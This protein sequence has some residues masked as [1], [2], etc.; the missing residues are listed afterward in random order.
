MSDL[1]S[2]RLSLRREPLRDEAAVVA[3]RLAAL[4]LDADRRQAVSEAGRA[5]V[6]RMR[7]SGEVTMMDNMLAEYGLSTDEGVALMCLAEAYLRVPDAPTLDALIKDKIGGRDWAEH[8][9]ESGSMLVNASTWGL[10][11]TGRLYGESWAEDTLLGSVRKMVRRVG[12]PV[13]RTAVAQCMKIM[14]A[15]FVLGRTIDEAW[16]NGGPLIEKGY[17]YSF[18]M[19]GEAARTA[20]DATH[21]FKAYANAIAAVGAR[22]TQADVHANSGISVKLSALHPRYEEVNRARVMAE[23]V[24]RLSALAEMAAAVN[25]GMTV[26]AEEADRL[27]LSLSVMEAV[28]RNPNLAGWGGF[29]IVVQAYLKSTLPTIDWIIALAR[30]LDR[31]LAVRLVKG[32]YWDAEIKTA[33]S[34]ALPAYPVFTR[35][36]STD[37]SY[38]ASAARLLGAQDHIYPMFAGHNA[39]TASAVLEMAGPDAVFEFQRLHGMGETLHE[40]LRRDHGHRCRIY[41]PVGVHKDLLAYLVRR[42]LENG[43]NSSFVNQALDKDVPA[44]ELTRDPATVVAQASSVAHAGIPLPP[45][46]FG[47]ERANSK[48]WN[49]NNPLMAA[50]LD[51]R[52]TPFRAARW[53]A[54]PMIGATPPRSGGEAVTNPADRDE[55][56][57]FVVS[58][59]ANDVTVALETTTRAFP[60]WRDRAPAER[61]ALLD[62]I[63]ALY[64]EHAP[65]LI[66]LLSREAGKTRW[67]G[68]LEVREAVDF[69]RYYAARSRA[70]LAGSGRKGRGVFVCISPWNFPLAIFTGQI[71][72]ALVS[73]NTV[74]A[75]PAEQTPLIAARAVALMREAGVPP[76]VLALLPGE[77]ASVGAALT[78]SPLVAGVCF[79]GSTETAIAIDRAQASAGTGGAPLIAETGGLNAMI[80]DSTALPEHAVRDIVAGAFQSAGQRCSALRALF[81]Q[82]DIADHLLTMLAGAVQE[83]VVGNP[84]EA[85]TD[86]GPVIDAEAKAVI[87][88][89]CEALT[90]AGRRLFVHDKA[91]AAKGGGF[92]A[93]VAFSLDR[94]EDLKSEIFGPVLHVIRFRNTEIDA[95]VDSINAAGYGL[96][97]GIHSRVDAQVERICSRARV[98]NI[99]VNRNQI[100]AVVGVQPFGGE[101][102]SGTGPK[103]GGPGYL[104]RFTIAAPVALPEVA[105]PASHGEDAAA[106]NALDAAR[107]AASV[108]PAW[109]GRSDRLAILEAA[110]RALPEAARPTASAVLDLAKPLVAPPLD[111][112]GVTGESNR[113]AL[114]GRGVVLC[115]GGGERPATALLAQ[116]LLGLAAGNAVLL[117]GDP[118]AG[119]IAALRKALA[120][121][122]LSAGLVQSI[123]ASDLPGLLREMP[124]LA[125]VAHEGGVGGEGLRVALAA[126]SGARVPLVALVDGVGRYVSERV[127][128]IDTTA[129]GGNASLLMLDEG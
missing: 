36:A 79:T 115:L 107:W 42:L 114:H 61:A 14:G 90:A 24:P 25:V 83:L 71:A 128:S 66:A 28:L 77:G 124:R 18:D 104:E 72:A 12:E 105:L 54:A 74:I 41:A 47:A 32:A 45:A 113:L 119:V 60:N 33:Q 125:L 20:A 1:A 78:A 19:L 98:G 129:S 69:C 39:H 87:T 15:Q 108:Q 30:D 21:Y 51:E 22:A 9:G 92:V 110:L 55:T 26:D 43:A 80:V 102:L 37:V 101:G 75:K 8:A 59:T 97:L 89:H 96:T 52:L 16:R 44:A 70:D 40:L 106:E 31:Q 62:R 100:G 50:E 49:L 4:P 27:D 6:E 122:G 82:E 99:Y 117:A 29:G 11:F 88:R 48:G 34:L 13:V 23:L 121:A 56:V 126:R 123:V 68:I 46:L 3:D 81:V 7:A 86:V 2:L 91:K 57:G 94:F 35:K 53:S 65:E 84:W 76:E 118:G 93:P 109:D 5:L 73:G 58:A 103:A 38:M 112:V 17:T 10:M 95:V 64:E 116:A 127:V 63:A 120:E 111:L 67:D 85:V